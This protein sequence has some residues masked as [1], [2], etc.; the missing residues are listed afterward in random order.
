MARGDLDWLW[1]PTD[2]MRDDSAFGVPEQI[3]ADGWKVLAEYPNLAV[4]TRQKANAAQNFSY[5]EHGDNPAILISFADGDEVYSNQSAEVEKVLGLISHGNVQGLMPS[6]SSKA[7]GT[8]GGF[9]MSGS[10]PTPERLDRERT[11]FAQHQEMQLWLNKPHPDPYPG[12]DEL[13]WF[14]AWS[15]EETMSLIHI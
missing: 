7:V 12:W 9:K 4:F 8:R 5:V 10:L 3:R 13:S 1:P 11:D 14:E 6:F 2:E 15:Q